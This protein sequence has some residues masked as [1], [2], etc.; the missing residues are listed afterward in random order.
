MRPVP[1]TR[2]RSTTTVSTP[3]TV[4]VRSVTVIV[5]VRLEPAIWYV[6]LVPGRSGSHG[7]SIR[8]VKSP[9]R[10]S[11][12]GMVS[13]STPPGGLGVGPAPQLPRSNAPTK[14]AGAAA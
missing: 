6:E 1:L 11:G 8:V 4:S 9:G 10:G 13:P 12:V 5:R 3:A 7:L 2:R 14:Q